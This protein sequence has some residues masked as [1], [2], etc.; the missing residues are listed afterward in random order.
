[1]QELEIW[2]LVTMDKANLLERMLGLLNEQNIRYCA[3]GGQAVNSY[4]DPVITL[5]LD[6]V[7][8]VQD[9]GDAEKLLEETFQ[10]ER[11]AH[12]LNVSL[13]DTRLR[14]QIQT[15][16]RYSDF[17][18]RASYR[19]I[20]GVVMPVAALRDV[21]QGKIWAVQ[22]PTRRPS[23]RQKDLTDISRLMEEFPYLSEMVPQEIQDRLFKPG[24]Q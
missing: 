14:V 11:F 4:V 5:D 7:I 6:L 17:V 16:P 23:K 19:T 21:L 3:I 9:L 1:M 2:K 15:D 8:A 22:D 10:V 12:S 20:L 24:I 18:D 13:P